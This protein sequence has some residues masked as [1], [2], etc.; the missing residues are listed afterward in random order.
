MTRI[1]RLPCLPL[2]LPPVPG[3]VVLF[4]LVCLLKRESRHS[5]NG[6][7]IFHHGD[8]VAYELPRLKRT[9]DDS[10]VRADTEQMD[11]HNAHKV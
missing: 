3:E 2:R 9:R 5:E 4:A 1:R 7:P 6:R 10:Q 8:T 11:V